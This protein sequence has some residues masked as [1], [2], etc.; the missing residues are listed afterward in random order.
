MFLSDIS[1]NTYIARVEF[2]ACVGL[3]KI[4]LRSNIMTVQSAVGKRLSGFETVLIG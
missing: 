3:K 1:R 2:R 4:S